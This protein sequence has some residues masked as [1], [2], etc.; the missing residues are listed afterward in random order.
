MLIFPLEYLVAIVISLEIISIQVNIILLFFYLLFFVFHLW[1]LFYSEIF[2][3]S[4]NHHYMFFSLSILLFICYFGFLEDSKQTCEHYFV[5]SLFILCWIL[6]YIFQWNSLALSFME[7][8]LCAYFSFRLLYLFPILI[9]LMV[10][11]KQMNI[12]LLLLC[13][14][15][16]TF[17]FVHL[18]FY[19]KYL[20]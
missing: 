9:L 2:Y 16:V 8:S 17:S 11:I 7:L 12:I 1:T 10:L 13:L 20:A 19:W 3:L 6:I 5:I 18:I 15:F 14:F 4:W